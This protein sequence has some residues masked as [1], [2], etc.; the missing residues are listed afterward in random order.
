MTGFINVRIPDTTIGLGAIRN[1]GQEAQKL[2]ASKIL[3]ITDKVIIQARIID[4]IKALLE[5]AKLQFDIYDG[6]KP[7]PPI[8]IIESITKKV[9]DNNYDLL[10]GI[11]G[12]SN[13]D[14]T[15]V[16]SAFANSSIDLSEYI[17]KH[18]GEKIEGKTISK[19]LIPTTAGTGAEWSIAAVVYDSHGYGH[20]FAVEQH[21]ADKVIIDPELTVN[22]PRKITAETGIDALTHA[23]E[24]YTCCTANIFSDML[25]STAIKL[26]G[27]NIRQVYAKGAKCVEARYNMSLAAAMA[28][29]AAIT[30][31]MG[32]C[33]LIAEGVQAKAHI[34]HGASL[35]IMLPAVMEYNV[36]GTPQKFAKITELLG[37]SVLGLSLMEA[38]SKSTSLVRKLI[39]DLELPK[40]MREVGIEETDI[41]LMA[42]QCYE[43]GHMGIS[44]WNPRD[45][46]E[47][48]IVRIYRASL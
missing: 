13:M 25:A 48:D 43:T 29:N 31:G 26:I 39:N 3:I 38:A 23:I 44:H 1:I 18:R 5:D 4:S 20:P 16:T 19:I 33:H 37:E 47:T 12:G 11:G 22:L 30:G 45:A 10:I 28:M 32:L 7:E 9:K 34:S 14:T 24:A 40:N 17:E 36:I 15:K 2:G 42:K 35:A 21:F 27:E 46:N 41:E 8:S 6:C